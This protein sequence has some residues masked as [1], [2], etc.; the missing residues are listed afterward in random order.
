[1]SS[2]PENLPEEMARIISDNSVLVEILLAGIIVDSMIGRSINFQ[3]CHNCN[4]K[5]NM[6]ILLLRDPDRILC[7][8]S[9]PYEYFDNFPD[10]TRSALNLKF[11]GFPEI[12]DFLNEIMDKNMDKNIG[13][14][15]VKCRRCDNINY[16][17]TPI[18]I[19]Q[20]SDHKFIESIKSYQVLS[21]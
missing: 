11:F 8:G 16:D 21:L 10:I 2:Y 19:T 9:V 17:V 4:T 13:L 6:C 3:Q 1:M 18:P 14:P 20:A 7:S 12:F 5:S 15:V